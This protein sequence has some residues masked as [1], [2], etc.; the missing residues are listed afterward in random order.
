MSPCLANLENQEFKKE[1]A[2]Q[3]AASFIYVSSCLPLFISQLRVDGVG[4]EFM[5]GA[6][7]VTFNP[8]NPNQLILKGNRLRSGFDS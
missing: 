5:Q 4:T 1:V 2:P 8:T 7:N 6:P 3:L